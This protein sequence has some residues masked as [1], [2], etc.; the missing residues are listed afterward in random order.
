MAT[1]RQ[2]EIFVRTAELGSMRLAADSLDISQPSVSKQLKALER[3]LGGA[4]FTRDRG[5]RAQLSEFGRHVLHDA[6]Q[7]LLIRERMKGT[8]RDLNEQEA[9]TIFVRN[10]MSTMIKQQLEQLHE[11]GLPQSTRFVI[12]DD[13]DDIF[14]KVKN[15]PGSYSI[16]RSARP[17]RASGLINVVLRSE[18]LS[19]Y[20]SCDLAAK[21]SDGT[22]NPKE[23]DVFTFS[24]RVE[25]ETWGL[26][27]LDLAGL[28]EARPVP[29]PQFVELTMDKLLRG[30]GV[31]ALLDWHARDY[32]K[33]GKLT[34]MGKQSDAAYLL[35]IA[36]GG[37][38]RLQ[39]SKLADIFSRVVAEN[40]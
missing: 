36:H 13:R 33:A 30:E 19:L 37:V 15:Q 21:I 1:S 35:L 7:S 31:C 2:L 22:L 23:I 38:D 4:L 32:V 9:P 16:L 8:S 6:T 5:Q 39:F 11:L 25:T 18:T 27:L 29:G 12:V 3:D 40:D 14:A 26:T 20:A 10:F 24:E 28:A 34:R 17:Y